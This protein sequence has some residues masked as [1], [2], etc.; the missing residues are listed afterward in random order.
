MALY[1]AS[2]LVSQVAHEPPGALVPAQENVG[3]KQGKA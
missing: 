3:G 1:L 2:L